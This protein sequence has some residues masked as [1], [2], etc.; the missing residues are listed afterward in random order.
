MA[1]QRVEYYSVLK[2]SSHEKT[3]RQLQ[4]TLL[5]ERRKSEMAA[6]YLHLKWLHTH[7]N[8]LYEFWKRQNCGDSKRRS[9]IAKGWG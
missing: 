5:N 2:K 4:Y 3:W 9:V 6:Y 1:H 8:Q 7:T